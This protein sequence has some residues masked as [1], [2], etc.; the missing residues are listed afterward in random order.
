MPCVFPVLSLKLLDLVK[1]AKSSANLMGHGVAFTGGVLATMLALSG[2]LLAL[3][4][5][6]HALGWG[7]Q[8][9]S[10]WVVAAL[11]LLFTAITFNL[12]GFYEFTFGSRIAD[13]ESVRKAPKTP[14]S[15]RAFSPFSSRVPAPRPSWAPRS[16]TP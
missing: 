4:G 11:I 13:A 15:S 16:A 8:L 10:A 9:Q 14:P 3:R 5:A 12:L 7:F 6:G 2:L 1:G